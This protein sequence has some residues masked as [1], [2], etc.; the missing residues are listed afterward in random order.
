MYNLTP[1]KIEQPLTP[2]QAE[3]IRSGNGILVVL[4]SQVTE[5]ERSL[6]VPVN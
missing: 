4:A 5:G 3:T 1:E 2:S 6:M